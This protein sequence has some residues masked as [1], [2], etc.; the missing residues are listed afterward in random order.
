M[1][2]APQKQS[3]LLSHHPAHSH[4]KKRRINIYLYIMRRRTK[5]S[6]HAYII[7]AVAQLHVVGQPSF[8]TKCSCSEIHLTPAGAAASSPDA[9][10]QSRRG[11]SPRAAPAQTFEKDIYGGAGILTC[12]FPPS[13]RR[14]N[15]NQIRVALMRSSKRAC[16][17]HIGKDE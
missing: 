12:T 15:S 6:Y 2:P 4:M 13:T 10:S 8:T 16:E 14:P 11:P 17:Y 5:E 9:R 1:P 7:A 3:Q